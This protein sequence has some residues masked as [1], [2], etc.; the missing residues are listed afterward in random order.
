MQSKYVVITGKGLACCM[1]EE[2]D[3]SN[4][5][6]L[7]AVLEAEATMISAGTELSRVFALKQGFTYPVRPG[8]SAIGRVIA[9]G[10]ALTD[11]EVGD[12]VFYSGPHASVCRFS[13]G[14]R[15]QGPMIFKVP[16]ELD[17]KEG[18]LITLGLVAMNGVNPT[19]VKLGDTLAVFG[20]G[21]IGIFCA[22]L[23]QELGARVIAVDPVKGRCECA[24]KMGVKE[25]LDC[26]PEQQAEK[27]MELTGGRGVDIA[28][29]VTGSS[30]AIMTEAFVLARNSQFVLL[31]SPRAPYETNVTPLLNAL[32]MKN[33]R[34]LGAF[35][36][37]YPV[38][39]TEGSRLSV[40]RN[41]RVVLE[42]IL[43]H[44]LDCSKL[45]SHVIRPEEAEQAY[46]GLM[47]DRD[48]YRCVVIDW[49]KSK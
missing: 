22:L 41:F 6:P 28:V 33:V 20:L 43:D 13:R 35:N 44:R 27:I 38:F 39:E 14:S 36:N 4:L 21:V 42:R 46:H 40:E 12:R 37:L 17:P 15:T 2:V 5:Q 11:I 47:Y 34:L 26:P 7:E 24:R 49:S 25:T 1:Q 29:D 8:Y 32:H 30:P 23:Y 3:V 9:K 45:I 16:N 10:S 31:G 18:T 19:D 48:V